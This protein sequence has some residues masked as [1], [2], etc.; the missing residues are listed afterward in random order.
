MR[1]TALLLAFGALSTAVATPAAAGGFSLYGSYWNTANADAVGGGG[2]RLG[3]PLGSTLD[4]D[5]RATYYEKLAAD[6]LARLGDAES[7]F[8]KGIRALPLD[9]GL[10]IDVARRD[11]VNPYVGAGGTYYRL[12]SDSGNVRDEVGWYALAGLEIGKFFVEA[13]YR[14]VT[15]TVKRDAGGPGDL[16]D[17]EL[18]DRVDVDLSGVAVNAGFTW[19]F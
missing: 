18:I 4:L 16:F 1:K 8:A 12:D 14:D 13:D 10:R 7:P 19:S 15:A 2:A 5:L 3:I 6:P 9:L 17:T 11:V